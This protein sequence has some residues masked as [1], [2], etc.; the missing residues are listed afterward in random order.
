MNKDFFFARAHELKIIIEKIHER[1]KE[2]KDN[3]TCFRYRRLLEVTK[4]TFDLNIELAKI[5]K[6]N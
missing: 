6:S 1:Q 5:A 2:E 4:S 3:E